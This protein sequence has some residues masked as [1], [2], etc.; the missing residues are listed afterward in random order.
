MR[1]PSFIL[2]VHLALHYIDLASLFDSDGYNSYPLRWPLDVLVRCGHNPNSCELRWDF[3]D[4]MCRLLV[5]FW[6]SL[7]SGMLA[8]HVDQ[9][10]MCWNCF[11]RAYCYDSTSKN[12][13]V[14]EKTGHGY[15]VSLRGSGD[16]SVTTINSS[17]T[18]GLAAHPVGTCSW[19]MLNLSNSWVSSQSAAGAAAVAVL[20]SFSTQVT[21]TFFAS[22]LAAFITL[23]AFAIDIA[24]Y[25]YVKSKMK[26]LSNANDNTLTGPGQSHFVCYNMVVWLTAT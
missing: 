26:K 19:R 17:W 6:Y 1:K 7:V 22:L 18:R 13:M 3:E 9:A 4:T 11:W 10:D 8:K 16:N 20:L 24:L 14:C 2:R 25:G 23:I 12:D 21:T 5:H 15:S